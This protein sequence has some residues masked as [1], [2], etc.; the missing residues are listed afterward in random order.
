MLVLLLGEIDL[1]VG[2]LTLLSVAL[3][4]QF[5]RHLGWPAGPAIVAAVAICTLLGLA[6]GAL[7]AWVRMPSFVVTLGGFLI[8]EG[9][10]NHI[11]GGA[12]SMCSIPS[13]A[14]SAPTT[15]PNGAGWVLA[16]GGLGTASWPIRLARARTRTRA[17]G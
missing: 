17:G 8:F 10:A 5:S 12:R 11:T 4:R 15:C 6:Q 2:Y 9:I 13:S 16:V 14:R 3:L 7:V 1:S